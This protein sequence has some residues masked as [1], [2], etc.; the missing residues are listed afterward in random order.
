MRTIIY[1]GTL[2]V[3]FFSCVI[4]ADVYRS[5]N[6]DGVVTYSD[7][8]HAQSETVTLP[9]ANIA[10]QPTQ[11]VTESPA[12]EQ[13]EKKDKKI[14]YTT[15]E[16]ASP[17]DQETIFNAPEISVSVKIDPA[18][19]IGDKIQFYFDGHPAGEPTTHTSTTLTESLVRGSHAISA[20]I[21]DAS[22]NEISKTPIITVFLHYTSI[23]NQPGR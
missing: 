10:V 16:I 3:I 23:L 2:I 6:S 11:T 20:G 13:T 17:A 7:Q 18:L 5:V 14:T 22:G 1:A 4:Y 19:Q 21:I 15:F 12:T 8:P 9:A